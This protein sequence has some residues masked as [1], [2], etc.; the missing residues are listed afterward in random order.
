[1]TQD[2]N[3]TLM[4]TELDVQPKM[5][6]TRAVTQPFRRY[7]HNAGRERTAGA[8]TLAILKEQ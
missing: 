3:P 5:A 4:P 2:R 7:P 6:L 1:M 8:R